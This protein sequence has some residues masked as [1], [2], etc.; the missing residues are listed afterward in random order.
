[1]GTNRLPTISSP[2]AQD[3]RN[4]L[5]R[6]R[7]TL[8]SDTLITKETLDRRL[9]ALSTP[10]ATAESPALQ[11]RIEALETRIDELSRPTTA[12]TLER[13][14]GD[15]EKRI[16]LL[17]E[18]ARSIGGLWDD[19]D[20]ETYT[21]SSE[22][23]TIEVPQDRRALVFITTQGYGRLTEASESFSGNVA[24]QLG[25]VRAG[26]G[27][28]MGLHTEFEGTVVPFN[29]SVYN[30]EYNESVEV[31]PGFVFD[32]KVVNFSAESI[33]VETATLA[34]V[35]KA[36]RHTAVVSMSGSIAEVYSS[37]AILTLPAKSDDA[38]D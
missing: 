32:K 34:V 22:R 35:L 9:A 19:I 15:V 33:Y 23:W 1:M 28:S 31:A 25:D 17:E 11:T 29:V 38:G 16:A 7:D 5:D 12:G 4:F 20:F 27:R 36:G 30:G 3:L 14:A 24:V 10:T 13:S 8:S 2:L 21:K 37:V 18:V 6:V 26:S